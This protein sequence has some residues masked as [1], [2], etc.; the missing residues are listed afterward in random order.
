MNI[1]N[2]IKEQFSVII[3][4]AGNRGFTIRKYLFHGTESFLR[5]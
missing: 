5:S 4:T 2:D 1:G 3:H